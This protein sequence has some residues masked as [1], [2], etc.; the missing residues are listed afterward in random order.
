MAG[1]S[2]QLKKQHPLQR[3]SADMKIGMIGLGRMG[4]NMADRLRAG[5]HEVVGYDLDPQ[6]GR[7]VD[8]I[9]ALVEALETPRI[10]WVMVPAGKPTQSTMD[11]LASLL[12]DDDLIVD[13]GN[14][15]FADDQMHARMLEPKG[16]H[17]VDVGTSN[18]IWGKEKGYALMVGGTDQDVERVMPILQTLKPEGENG[19]VHAG[20]TGAGHYTK[21][22]HNGIEYGMMQAL[23]EGYAVMD[24]SDLVKDPGQVMASWRE[25]SVINS[26]LLDLLV[27]ALKEDPGLKHI[28]GKANE[29]GEAKWMIEDALE[30]GVPTPVTTASLYAR[31]DSQIA[32]P[33]T[34]K[35]VSALRKEFGGHPVEQ[36]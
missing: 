28:A 1:G 13:G 4:G 33:T 32:D 3:R 6:S 15:R 29:S 10:I 35:V 30:L 22:V 31:Q 36:E 2:Q 14:T 7:D 8:S 23:A 11:Q 27:K 12:S 5:G 18:G 26:W 17:L 20:G 9:Q 21:M 16:I 24:A 25:G 19:L 34:M